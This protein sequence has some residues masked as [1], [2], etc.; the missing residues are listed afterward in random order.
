VSN[1]QRTVSV[2][3]GKGFPTPVEPDPN[4]NPGSDAALAAGCKCARVD[5]CYGRGF[6]LTDFDTKEVTTG[7]YISSNCALH[8][9]IRGVAV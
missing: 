8:W 4:A 1:R 3:Y 5:N 7:F 2:V 6:P 9:P